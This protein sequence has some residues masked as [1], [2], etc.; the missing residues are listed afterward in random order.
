MIP[1][2][3]GLSDDRGPAPASAYGHTVT[4][5]IYADTRLAALYDVFDTPRDDLDAYFALAK[6]LN[7]QRIVDLGCGTGTLPLKLAAPGRDV[8]GVDPA[9]ASLDVARSKDGA[10]RVT[11]IEGDA[12]AISPGLGAD[13][14]VMTGN[15]A[16]A[17]LTDNV[18]A[19][20]LRHVNAALRPDGYFVFETRR[21]GRRAWEEW[22]ETPPVTMDVPGIGPVERHLEVTDVRLPL[23]TFRYTYRFLHDGTTITSD[24]TIRFRDRLELETDLHSSGLHVDDVRQAPDRPGREFVLITRRA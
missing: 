19:T 21:P 18:W 13:L 12:T 24:S 15:A 3:P 7:A 10:H 16:Q 11:W 23:V 4:D 17:I 14:V 1:E 22:I 5:P 6:E 20:T 2:R 9:A 8:I